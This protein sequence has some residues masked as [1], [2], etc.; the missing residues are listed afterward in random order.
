MGLSMNSTSEQEQIIIVGIKHFKKIMMS[1]GTI[2]KNATRLF[3][4]DM[5]K[6]MLLHLCNE[7]VIECDNSIYVLN[8]K[9]IA[10]YELDDVEKN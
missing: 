3:T 7:F 6:K 2:F 5:N 10:Y 4:Q 1:N 9:H 8:K